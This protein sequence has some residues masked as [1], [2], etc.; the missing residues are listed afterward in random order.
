M[1]LGWALYWW[2][3]ARDVK[4]TRW[5]ESPLSRAANTAPLILAFLLL[6]PSR[7]PIAGI[8]ERFLPRAAWL[9]WCG[10]M[11]T[12]VGLLFA[13]LARR[14]LGR[15]WSGTVTIKV[16]HALVTNGP[17]RLARHPIYSGLLLGFVGTAL[18][19][20]EWRAVAAVALAAA[21]IWRRV[22]IE[23]RGM[24]GQFGAAYEAYARRVAAL[25]PFLL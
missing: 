25:I 13:I 21:A 14:Q 4:A 10:T 19:I 11:L 22:V 12:A 1:W 23:E 15:N 3:A 8:G 5:R 2:A 9:L 24:R 17:Y 16:D 20:G 18:A 6:S 7:M